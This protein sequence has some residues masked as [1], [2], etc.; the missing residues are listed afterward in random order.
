MGS[1]FP[2]TAALVGP[3]EE[4]CSPNRAARV[5]A[6]WLLIFAWLGLGL[7]CLNLVL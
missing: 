4:L 5:L 2:S 6:T 3:L 7:I 1:D